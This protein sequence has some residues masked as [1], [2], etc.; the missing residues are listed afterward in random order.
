MKKKIFVVIISLGVLILNSCNSNPVGP[1]IILEIQPGRRDY[2]WTEDTL[3]VPKGELAEL[4]FLWGSGPDDIWAIASA[5]SLSQLGIWHYVGNNWKNFIDNPTYT[6]AQ[7][8]IWGVASNDIWLGNGDGIIW[9]YDGKVWNNFT[10]LQVNRYQNFGIQRLWGISAN[11][12]YAVGVAYNSYFNEGQLGGIFMYDGTKWKQVELPKLYLNFFQLRKAKN[13]DFIIPA[14][15][16]SI[17]STKL[18]VWNG[19]EFRVLFSD[20]GFSSFNVFNIG[21]T[22]LFNIAKVVYSYENDGSYKKWKDFSST[23]YYG[24]ILCSRSEKDFFVGSWALQGINHYNGTDLKLIYS[25]PNTRIGG[26]LIFEKDV[27]FTLLDL[28]TNN[29]RILHG[30]LQN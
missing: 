8:S 3:K 29:T 17:D 24:P 25:A 22:T 9:R 14:F 19:K 18:I 10:R 23:D 5:S 11:E 30:H 26:G 15:K 27:F 16:G 21:E 12:I 20:V 2:V 13:G 4:S 1:P 6:F 7:T 28:N